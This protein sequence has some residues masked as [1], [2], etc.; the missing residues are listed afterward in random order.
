MHT[1]GSWVGSSQILALF[2]GFQYAVSPIHSSLEFQ[3]TSNG[4]V[5]QDKVTKRFEG[6]FG[7]RFARLG[8]ELAECLNCGAKLVIAKSSYKALRDHSCRAKPSEIAGDKSA[9]KLEETARKAFNEKTTELI[10]NMVVTDNMPISLV[11]KSGF[12]ALVYHLTCRNKPQYVIPSR[13]QISR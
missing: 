10:I 9:N 1:T 11:E 5:R 7:G 2:V 6:E 3:G 4:F 13:R 8:K 12:Q